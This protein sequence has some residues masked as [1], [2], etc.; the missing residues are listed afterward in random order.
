MEADAAVQGPVNACSGQQSSLV[1][2]GPLT[3]RGEVRFPL[4]AAEPGCVEGSAFTA[5]SSHLPLSPDCPLPHLTP[6]LS[7]PLQGLGTLPARRSASG[8]PP[9]TAPDLTLPAK[10]SLP[11]M[12]I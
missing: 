12:P 1:W 10:T 4:F 9:I 3:T 2:T 11:K 8:V 7:C 6:G 5:S